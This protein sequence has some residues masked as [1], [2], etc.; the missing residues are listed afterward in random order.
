MGF[1]ERRNTPRDRLGIFS[2]RQNQ[3]NGM[4]IKSFAA[5][6]Q[7]IRLPRDHI[8]LNRAGQG[9]GYLTSHPLYAWNLRRLVGKHP[10]F[11][12][13]NSQQT[14]IYL[15]RLHFLLK[16]NPFSQNENVMEAKSRKCLSE[17]ISAPSWDKRSFNG[18]VD[19]VRKTWVFYSLTEQRC[20]CIMIAF[21]QIAHHFIYHTFPTD[22]VTKGGRNRMQSTLLCDGSM[23]LVSWIGR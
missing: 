8:T 10:T 14:A 22:E 4:L 18:T 6:L 11:I 21:K 9:G 5:T 16:W 2:V 20:F 1:V 19:S 7:S 17:I 23:Q 12:L 13:L 3:E 15:E